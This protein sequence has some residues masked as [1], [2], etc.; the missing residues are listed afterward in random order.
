MGIRKYPTEL[1]ICTKPFP[2]ASDS[3]T[4]SHS[5]Y[6]LNV[7]LCE[8]A[9]GQN[10]MIHK[11]DLIEEEWNSDIR[12]RHD[13]HNKRSAVPPTSYATFNLDSRYK[14]VV[15]VEYTTQALAFPRLWWGRYS[16]YR[17]WH[18]GRIQSHQGG[19]VCGDGQVLVQHNK[20]DRWSHFRLD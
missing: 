6:T 10:T 5:R 17:C 12:Y 3:Y 1:Y 15:R 16:I 4:D 14:L 19:D 2:P 9:T 20:T 11:S 8:P 18:G 7:V 13:V